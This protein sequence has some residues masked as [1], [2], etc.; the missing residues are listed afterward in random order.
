MLMG[1][2]FASESD[3]Y[4]AGFQLGVWTATAYKYPYY[5][6][7]NEF[8]NTKFQIARGVIR[9]M[10]DG[11]KSVDPNGK[12]VMGGGTWLHYGF[13]QMLANGTQPDGTTGHLPVNWDI[14]AWH[15]YSDMGDIT[16]ACG[17][18]GCHDVL[19][20]LQQMGK[21][22]GSTSSACARGMARI[23]RSRPISSATR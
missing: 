16:N 5:E 19:A 8:D 6:V 15:G 21:P 12:I 4:S 14:T 11:V 7:S 9:G 20:T 17:G 1:I 3:A 13:D 22:S 2:D 18:T 10:I 23:S